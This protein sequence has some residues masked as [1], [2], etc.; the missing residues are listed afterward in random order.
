M[1]KLMS[2]YNDDYK[3]L[4]RYIEEYIIRNSLGTQVYK[5]DQLAQSLNSDEGFSYVRNKMDNLPSDCIEELSNNIQGIVTLPTIYDDRVSYSIASRLM[6]KVEL[7][8]KIF[9]FDHQNYGGF[10]CAPTGRVSALAAPVKCLDGKSKVFTIFE[11]GIFQFIHGVISLFVSSYPNTLLQG[12][13]EKEWR[14]EWEK[15]LSSEQNRSALL[16]SKIDLNEWR[17]FFKNYN[18]R[19]EL[20]YTSIINFGPVGQ[21]IIYNMVFGCELFVAAHEYSHAM[22]NHQ[23]PDLV[24]SEVEK[25]A[26]KWGI[27]IASIICEG[28]G[29]LMILAIAG[30][31]I[32][33]SAIE[34]S[35]PSHYLPAAERILFV[36]K[37]LEISDPIKEKTLIDISCLMQDIFSD[38]IN[39]E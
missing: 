33:F 6:S 26:D 39:F 36:I 2:E 18:V 27:R 19:G 34:T 15:Y 5:E 17:D 38:I 29:I 10:C 8:A 25:E 16:Q 7:V 20:A 11:S 21:K 13:S 22:M 30:I 31:A 9:P 35:D 14:S 1:I 24:E 23:Q 12:S 28:E 4:E 32:F 3:K 37:S